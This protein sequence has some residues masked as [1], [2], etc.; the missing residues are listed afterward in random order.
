MSRAL[1]VIA[2]GVSFLGSVSYANAG[3]FDE[4]KDKL[5]SESKKE[6]KKETAKAANKKLNKSTAGKVAGNR[7][8]SAAAA[9]GSVSLGDGP[10]KSLTSMTSCTNLKPKN[11]MTGYEGDY[12]FQNGFKKEERSGFIKRQPG[13]LSDGCILPSLQSGQLAYM[14]VDT[15]AYEALGSSNDW[16]MQCLRSNNPGAG[17]LSEKEPRTEAVYSVKAMTGKHMMLH[18]GNSEGIAECAEGSNSSRAS[19]WKKKLKKNGKTMLSIRAFTSTL[20]PKGGEK[21]YCQYYNKKAQKSLFAFE[22]LRSP[23]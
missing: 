7:G 8:K 19:A 9:S 12:T 20:A 22:Y 21:V 15:K 14:E 10:S 11:I 6:A 5:K 13:K 17:A 3:I 1:I 18:C 23:S 4:L 2:L 16:T